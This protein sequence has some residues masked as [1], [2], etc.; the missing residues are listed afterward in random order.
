M[1]GIRWQKIAETQIAIVKSARAKIALAAPQVNK[2][3]YC[4]ASSLLLKAVQ[5]WAAFLNKIILSK[6]K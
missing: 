5:T 4:R 1:P 6:I 2:N 3:S